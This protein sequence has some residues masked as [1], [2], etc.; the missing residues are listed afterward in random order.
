[1]LHSHI[2]SHLTCITF[3]VT[4]L[5]SSISLAGPPTG[6]NKKNC[7]TALSAVNIQDISFGEFDANTG[8][9]VTIATDGSRTATGG[10]ILAGGATTA[11]IFEVSSSLPG[12]EAFPVTIKT[13]NTTTL[14]EPLGS[15]LLAS[16]FTTQP[17]SGFTIIPGTPTLVEVGA[18]LTVPATQ[19]GGT[20]DTLAPYTLTFR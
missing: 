14:T 8:G 4:Y 15:T 9:T 7:R 1:M 3:V 18:D 6:P 10:I 16:N 19:A 5:C 12:C 13:P 20:Y 11:A 2:R 17:A